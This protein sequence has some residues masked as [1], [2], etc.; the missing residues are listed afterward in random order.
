MVRKAAVGMQGTSHG[1]STVKKAYREVNADLQPTFP[2]LFQSRTPAREMVQPKFRVGLPQLNL[3]GDALIDGP[4][5]V[6][7]T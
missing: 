3:S 1:V 7:P 5:V 2:F 4:R 6:S